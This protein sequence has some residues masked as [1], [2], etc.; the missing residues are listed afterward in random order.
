MTI[1]AEE[2]HEVAE[3]T[4]RFCLLDE[5]YRAGSVLV[6]DIDGL[7]WWIAGGPKGLML[8]RASD[9]VV[10][11]NWVIPKR[12]VFGA[13]T[14][15]TDELIIEERTIDGDTAIRVVGDAGSVVVPLRHQPDLT[16]LDRAQSSP[17]IAATASVDIL[18]FRQL[19][20][21]ATYGPHRSEEQTPPL[22]WIRLDGGT[23]TVEIDWDEF[24]LSSYRL[25][26]KGRGS[27]S[28]AADATQLQSVL[29]I[30]EGD[31]TIELTANPDD[32]LVLRGRDRRALLV[33]V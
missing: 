4:N 6:A 1:S 11:T 30:F 20:D 13:A 9:R 18:S 19:L 8:L 12:L 16:I 5:R 28:T 7:R 14:M 33:P 24:G 27:A 3:M 2:I 25:D 21:A 29:E 10:S 17:S 26:G 32:E 23:V 22:F 15:T 31:V